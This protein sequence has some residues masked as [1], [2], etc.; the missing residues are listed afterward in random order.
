MDARAPQRLVGI[1]VSHPGDR[2]LIEESRLD[3]CAAPLKP[4][5]K[6]PS[7]EPAL[8]RLAPETRRQVRLQLVRLDEEP[9]AEAADIAIRN[10]RSV[11]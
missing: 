5:R 10:I 1:D 7:G 9:R 11:V 3:R 8:E 6:S 4:A 2:A